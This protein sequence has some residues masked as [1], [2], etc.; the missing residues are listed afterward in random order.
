MITLED[1]S[2]P[3][4]VPIY[5]CEHL[6]DSPKQNNSGRNGAFLRACADYNNGLITQDQLVNVTQKEGFKYVL[7]TAPGLSETQRSKRIRQ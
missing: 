6:R 7:R 4:P 5:L 1:L 3:Y 2:L